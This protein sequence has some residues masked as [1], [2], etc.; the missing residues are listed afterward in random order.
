VEVRSV[1]YGMRNVG[2]GTL[3]RGA[4]AAAVRAVLVSGAKNVT[5][6]V[7]VVID[8]SAPGPVHTKV[9]SGER[10][11]RSEDGYFEA[12]RAALALWKYVKG[13]DPVHPAMACERP[14]LN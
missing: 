5:G 3:A 9:W 4:R 1:E 6:L 8:S 2:P 12:F 14:G 11:V 7:S 10:G 13:Y